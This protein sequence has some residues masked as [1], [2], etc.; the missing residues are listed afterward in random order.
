LKYWRVK[1]M[2]LCKCHGKE[3][4]YDWG[5]PYCTVVQKSIVN[6]EYLP[7]SEQIEVNEEAIKVGFGNPLEI[8]SKM[9]NFPEN[10]T[11]NLGNLREP[12][13]RN[14]SLKEIL[15]EEN[16]MYSLLKSAR[17]RNERIALDMDA[18]KMCALQWIIQAQECTRS[19]YDHSTNLGNAKQHI[20]RIAEFVAFYGEKE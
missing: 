12:S 11:A 16:R 9:H 1:I 2:I 6:R 5:K 3:I 18:H 15:T 7:L 8:M 14:E 13:S 19:G 20:D 4:G 10:P 17:V